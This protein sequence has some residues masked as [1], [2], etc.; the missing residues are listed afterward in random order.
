MC[1]APH[2]YYFHAFERNGFNQL[3]I[4]VRSDTVRA[5]IIIWEFSKWHLFARRIHSNSW[6]LLP[7]KYLF[8]SFVQ[9]RA[10]L[11]FA[12]NIFWRNYSFH[13]RRSQARSSGRNDDNTPRWLADYVK[14][15]AVDIMCHRWWR[16]SKGSQHLNYNDVR[17]KNELWNG[18]LIGDVNMFHRVH[19]STE[20]IN[21]VWIQFLLFFLSFGWARV[22]F[23][24]C[25]L[26]ANWAK[27]TW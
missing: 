5:L 6:Y 20:A 19:V 9:P 12:R 25:D 27:P 7:A 8:L 24:L 1:L 14:P 22:I 15:V 4:Y 3:M 11:N 17:L 2:R 18:N 21:I 26:R 13:L 23:F 10:E 16:M